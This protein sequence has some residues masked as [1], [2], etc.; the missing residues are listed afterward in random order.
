MAAYN[1]AAYIEHQLRSI[2][3]ELH[4][5]DE[6]IVVDDASRD[7][8][9]DIVERIGDPR[10]RLIRQQA[11]RGYVR[12]FETAILAANGEILLLADQDD[13]WIPGR[14]ALLVAAAQEG[15]VAAS[16]LVLLGSDK[17]LRS[18]L[19]GRPWILRGSRSGHRVR[20]ELRMLAGDMPY[21]GCAMALRRDMVARVAPFPDFLTESHDLWIATVGNRGGFMRHVEAP[22][23]RR[24][25]HD[26]NASTPRP[27]GLV[28]VLKSRWMLM[29]AYVEAGRRVR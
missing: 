18:P 3:E 28:H 6:V 17:S 24:R 5:G 15:G 19:T 21:F 20:N 14:R 16:N 26:S 11:N 10:V 25:V 27:R 12:T 2:L 22:T 8:T 4:A 23:I 29:K 13:E 1:G 7:D 9:V